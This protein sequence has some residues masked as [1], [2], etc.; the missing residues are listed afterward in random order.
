MSREARGALINIIYERRDFPSG[1][2][3]EIFWYH[4]PR[5]GVFPC[6]DYEPVVFAYNYKHDLCFVLVRRGW[7]II[8]TNPDE[9]YWPPEVLFKGVNHH[10]FVR[11]T[12]D[13]YGDFDQSS[14]LRLEVVNVSSSSV[15]SISSG[16]DN[17][18][19]SFNVSG[20]GG[21]FYEKVRV[22]MRE[23]CES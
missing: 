18:I 6:E 2:Y 19:P 4:W 23:S 3:H 9:A 15:R 17:N 16:Q 11:M 12:S 10:Q 22:V 1:S 7:K 20:I 14:L 5:D 13:E 21:N 8:I